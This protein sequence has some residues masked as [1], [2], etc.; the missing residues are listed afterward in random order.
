MKNGGE[1]A[2]SQT[3]K[4]PD[5]GRPGVAAHPFEAKTKT[6]DSVRARRPTMPGCG[7]TIA[8]GTGT[9]LDFV[10]EMSLERFKRAQVA[11]EG[12][13]EPA[14]AELRAGRK[15]GHWIWYV[16]PQLA[17]LG[18]SSTARLFALRDFNEACDYL[19]DPLLRERLLLASEAVA[20]KLGAGMAL[21]ELM[22]GT[23]DALKLVSSLTLFEVVARRLQ[24][25]GA[26]PSL[27][28]LMAQCDSILLVASR[29]GF[30]RCRFTLAHTAQE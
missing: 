16:F 5:P 14:L 7:P 18:Q 29:Q 10:S 19:R 3:W 17:G 22:G 1:K 6:K 20:G 25:Q 15:T 9:K 23:I 12:G 2:R 24:A 21:V 28:R 26:D 13:F 11:G 8:V 30:P 4:T 27:A